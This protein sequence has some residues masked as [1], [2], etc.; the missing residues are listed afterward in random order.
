M[1]TSM[2][3]IPRCP[4]GYWECHLFKSFKETNIFWVL[5]AQMFWGAFEKVL[6]EFGTPMEI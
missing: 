6:K 4:A 2:E 5:I 3:K 1:T